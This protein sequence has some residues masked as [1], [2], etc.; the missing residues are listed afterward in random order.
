MTILFI[1]LGVLMVICGFSCM[2]TPLWT[3]LNLEY[4]IVILVMVFGV[5]GIIKNIVEKRFGVGFVFSILST[6]L[7]I[8]VLCFPNIFVFANGLLFYFVAGW[9]VLQGV[10]SIYNSIVAKNAV[11]GKMW[12]FQLIIGILTLI[13]G[14]FTFFQPIIVPLSFGILI[15]IFFIDTGFTMIFS[16]AVADN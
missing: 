12:V 13:L 10:V 1:I 3:Y 16:A 14:C 5:F 4:F 9:F 15:G 2:F 11:G 6:I 8:L 7:G